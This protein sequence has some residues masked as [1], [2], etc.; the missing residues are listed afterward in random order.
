MGHCYRV[1]GRNAPGA[2]RGYRSEAELNALI[3]TGV[4]AAAIW[5]TREALDQA[6]YPAVKIV[7]SSGF[8]PE[9]CR[10]MALAK[11]PVDVIGTG[12]FLPERWSETYATADV[13]AYPGEATKRNRAVQG[14]RVP[15]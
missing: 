13:I 5:H 4:S 14:K 12:S 1:L 9:K 10:V 11:A 3:G 7:A 2:I 15:T 8:G 6:G